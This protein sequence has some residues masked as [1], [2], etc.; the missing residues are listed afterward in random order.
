LAAGAQRT[1]LASNFNLLVVSEAVEDIPSFHQSSVTHL[2]TDCEEAAP[3]NHIVPVVFLPD[4]AD[5]DQA[6][7]KI[8]QA[9]RDE[10]LGETVIVA[11]QQVFCED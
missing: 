10:A 11:V 8:G 9:L 5:V 1:S 2:W 3:R 6:I 7:E 4:W